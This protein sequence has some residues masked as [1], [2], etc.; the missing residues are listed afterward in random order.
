MGNGWT[1]REQGKKREVMATEKET[2]I[3][4]SPS[5]FCAHAD[6]SAGV[7]TGPAEEQHVR[8][9]FCRR[10]G[11]YLLSLEDLGKLLL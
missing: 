3:D 4:L 10:S 6:R 2:E 5:C 1:I 9:C 8:L 11:S 7:L